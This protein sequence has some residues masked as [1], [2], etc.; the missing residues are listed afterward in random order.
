MIAIVGNNDGPLRLMQSMQK[1]NLTPVCVG[2]Q[3]PVDVT[4]QQKYMDC[5]TI[6][7]RL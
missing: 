5:I 6:Y 2:L 3:K 1:V 4:L 7:H